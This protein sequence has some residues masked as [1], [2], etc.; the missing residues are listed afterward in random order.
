MEYRFWLSRYNKPV[1][2]E[3][4]HRLSVEGVLASYI[5][6]SHGLAIVRKLKLEM[7]RKY[8]V[9]DRHGNQCIHSLWGHGLSNCLLAY[10][11]IYLLYVH[12]RLTYTIYIYIYIVEVDFHIGQIIRKGMTWRMNL[13]TYA[14]VQVPKAGGITKFYVSCQCRAN[15]F[16]IVYRS[17]LGL[18][19]TLFLC[20]IPS[21]WYN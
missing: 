6:Q 1:N 19:H 18:I 20:I 3:H 12:S 17:W 7:M 14:H 4:V 11:H 16:R 9:D 13:I 10:I 2:L 15:Y 8:L 5:S 21:S